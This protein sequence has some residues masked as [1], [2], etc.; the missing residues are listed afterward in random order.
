MT[1]CNYFSYFPWL[2]GLPS[3][4]LGGVILLGLVYLATRF[5]GGRNNT[6][7]GKKSDRDDSFEILKSR[8]AR[9]D[10]NQ[11]EYVN[12]KRILFGG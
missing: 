8:F 2:N 9:G 4:L 7:A 12:M 3:A 1:G 10:I 5:L 11:E 6:P